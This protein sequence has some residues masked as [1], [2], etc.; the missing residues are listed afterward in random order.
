MVPVL[1]LGLLALR[2][3]RPALLDERPHLTPAGLPVLLV[4]DL[5]NEALELRLCESFLLLL[6]LDELGVLHG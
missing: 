1:D 2:Q 5:L 6:R 3:A 4:N